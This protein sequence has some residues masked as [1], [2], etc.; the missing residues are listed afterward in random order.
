MRDI[1]S[2]LGSLWTT[3]FSTVPVDCG[4]DLPGVQEVEEWREWGD[5][6][7]TPDQERIEDFIDQLDLS[8]LTILHVGIG[9]SKLAVRFSDRVKGIVG[10]A[11][12]PDEVRRGVELDLPN[13]TPILHN[14]YLERSPREFGHFDIIID[15]NPTAFACCRRHLGYMM[16]NFAAHIRPN[17]VI[18]TD[19]EGLGWV[20][21]APDSNPRWGFDFDDWSALGEVFGLKARRLTDSVYA[22]TAPKAAF[23]KRSRVSWRERFV[24]GLGNVLRGRSYCAHRKSTSTPIRARSRISDALCHSTRGIERSSYGAA[25]NCFQSRRS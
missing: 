14:K 16:S 19:R 15:N 3:R 7:T 9:N 8:D 6:E 17:G 2:S 18:L 11:I 22:L 5:R 13:Y 4:N 24:R 23:R 10:I 20:V 1:S 12:S 25:R 21:N